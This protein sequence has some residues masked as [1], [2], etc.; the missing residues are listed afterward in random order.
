M[1]LEMV[2]RRKVVLTDASKRRLGSTVQWQTGFQLLVER[3]RSAS[4]QQPG[5]SGSIFGP[6]YLSARPEGTSCLSLFGHHDSGVLYKSSGR[7]LLEA[8]LHS[9]RAH[10]G[11]GSAQLAFA[12]SNAC[13]GQVKPGSRHA[14]S[15]QCPLRQVDAPPTR[16]VQEAQPALPHHCPYMGSVHGVKGLEETSF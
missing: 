2:Y 10:L 14:I 13:V 12:E 4:H 7:S 9:S 1:P 5:N 8:P 3:R 15:E 11:M 16:R 6:L